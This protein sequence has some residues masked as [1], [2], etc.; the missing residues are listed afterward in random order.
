MRSTAAPAAIATSMP[1]PRLPFDPEEP[2]PS[3]PWYRCRHSALWS[4]PPDP[5]TTPRVARTPTSRPSCCVRTPTTA[6]SSTTSS[7][8]G[9]DSHSSTPSRCATSSSDAA[10]AAPM[11]TR[12]RPRTS[13]V[14]TRPMTWA[15]RIIP[16]GVDQARCSSQKSSVLTGAGTPS[17]PREEAHQGPIRFTSNGSTSMTRPT[18]PPGSSG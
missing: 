5:S 8:T 18:F 11:P 3:I 6:P 13:M 15:P 7:V 14:A 9:A 12:R 10:S 17:W 1:V 16:P 2:V 4:N